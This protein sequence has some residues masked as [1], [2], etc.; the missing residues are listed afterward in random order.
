[1]L[2]GLIYYIIYFYRNRI[3]N[4]INIFNIVIK[5]QFTLTNDNTSSI[6]PTLHQ[7]YSE[8]TQLIDQCVKNT[9]VE[10]RWIP[11][12]NWIQ[13]KLNSNPPIVNAI[14]IKVMLLLNIYYDYYCNNQLKSIENLI[15]IIE[16]TLQ[17][18]DEERRVYCVLLQPE[19]NMIGYPRE[20]NHQDKN[21]LNDLF[22]I[23]CQDEEQLPIRHTLVNLMAMILLSGKEN[24][25][26]TF[27]F[28]PLKLEGTYGEF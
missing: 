2:N 11:L 15:N 4:V 24:T 27:A 17:P 5:L 9:N 28:E 6:F 21:Y 16:N 8:L 20:N 19:Q 7:P 25:L 3:F 22:K 23:D 26:W 1:M 18:S 10:Q 13:S 14:E 12:T